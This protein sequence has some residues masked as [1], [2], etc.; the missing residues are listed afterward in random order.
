MTSIAC[1]GRGDDDDIDSGEPHHQF[2]SGADE[3]VLHVFD[4]PTS[5]LRSY[6]ALSG[7][8]ES[9]L[10]ASACKA[11]NNVASAAI[12]LWDVKR[13]KC[14]QILKG[15]HRSTV[16][17]MSFS[18]NGKYLA[19]SGK[20]RRICIWRRRIHDQSM[21]NPDEFTSGYELSAAADSAH[22]RIIWSIHFCPKSPDILASGSRDGLIKTWRVVEAIDGA[23]ELKELV[24]FEPS[25]KEEKTPIT[26][27]AFAEDLFCGIYDN[28]IECGILSIGTECGRIEIWAIPIFSPVH[29]YGIEYP[30][31]KLL[32]TLPANDTHF[33]T[34]NKIAW[35]PGM[36]QLK[37]F[38][39]Y[40]PA[41]D[42]TVVSGFT[43]LNE[44]KCYPIN[45]INT[46]YPLRMLTKI[47]LIS[48]YTSNKSANQT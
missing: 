43:S 46:R 10:V 26:A 11:R 12:R 48:M 44:Q 2:N 47:E 20:D 3:K 13:G 8:C 7:K 30:S 38:I 21:S 45:L 31:P 5:T 29:N 1:I 42:E 23:L 17:T 4:A 37:L 41:V 34:V 39:Q 25:F 28:N 32:H 14:V 9:S 18:R 16:S 27:V 33:D 24:R 6:C 19:S 22:K 15:G 40:L 36:T 35:H